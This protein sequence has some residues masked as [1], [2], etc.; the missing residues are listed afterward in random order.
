MIKM[1]KNSSIQTF[2]Q[3]D[4][5]DATKKE[6]MPEL[7]I[8][9]ITN[10]ND[11]IFWN[12]IHGREDEFF[13]YLLDYKQYPQNT[14]LFAAIDKNKAVHGLFII[15]RGRTI[16]L[17][18]TREAAESF[19]TYLNREKIEIKEI[20][21]TIKEHQELLEQKF[22]TYKMKFNLY[23][24]VLHKGN[25]ILSDGQ[26]P[27][28]IYSYEFLK[29]GSE[30]LIAAF[31]RRVDPVFWGD[32]TANDITMDELHPFL[33]VLDD[34]GDIISLAGLWIDEQI[35]IISIIGTDPKYRNQGYATSIVASGV[36]YLFQ[37]TDVILIHVRVDNPPAV[38]I[39]KKVG[40]KAKYEYLVIRVK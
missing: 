27:Y 10:E 25:E 18:G 3:K 1:V 40:Y 8:M 2:K 39:Y 5:N 28:E 22:P 36:K 31:L 21:G 7:S 29:P 20:T 35:G 12:H 6:Y 9:P 17:R 38:H 24:M 34:K 11:E 23:R 30:E 14:Q 19:L 15:W 33:A 4:K 37:H 13:F 16:Q 26:N 32:H